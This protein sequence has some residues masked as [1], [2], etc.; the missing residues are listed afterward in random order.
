MKK[1]AFFGIVLGLLLVCSTCQNPMISDY[2]ENKPIEKQEVATITVNSVKGTYL[3]G[4][5]ETFTATLKNPDGSTVPITEGTWRSEFPDVATVDSAGLVTALS[6]G[7]IYIACDHQGLTGQKAILVRGDYRGSWSGTYSI[8]RCTCSGDFS[9]AKFCETQ[10]GSG[11]PIA[12]HLEMEGDVLK[13]TIRLGDLSTALADRPELDMAA[14]LEG[15]LRSDPYTITVYIV[16]E[17]TDS[18]PR[19]PGMLLAYT[20]KSMTGSA[21]VECSIHDLTKIGG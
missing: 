7:Y 14:I 8:D 13:G 3:I 17:W 18:G 15:D 2:D 16:P 4:D 5:S 9:A 11:Y 10:G 19:F 12:F 21:R 20:A 1:G 6:E